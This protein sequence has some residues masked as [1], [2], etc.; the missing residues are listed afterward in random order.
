MPTT[1]KARTKK[2]S[3]TGADA[4]SLL[5]KDHEKVRGLLKR[6]ESAADR[7]DDRAEALLAQVDREV[8]I[9]SQVEEEIFY[10][11]FKKAA[12]SK[13]DNKLF[14]EATEEHHVVDMV[15]PEVHESEGGDE[16][17]AA[18]TKVLKDLIEHHAEEEEKQMFPKAKKLIAREEL[19][20]L[21]RRIKAR[22][23]ELGAE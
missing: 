14:F 15:M 20:E 17:F 19:Q 5:K 23:R 9:H 4:I 18:K 2:R 8:K 22:K 6:L 16:T 11:A 10:P 3:T 1:K 13:E 21:G 12:R 7:G